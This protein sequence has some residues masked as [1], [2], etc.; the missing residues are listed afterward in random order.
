[1]NMEWAYIPIQ[2]Y[3]YCIYLVIIFLEMV[4]SRLRNW[5]K[6]LFFSGSFIG[7]IFTTIYTR[8]YKSRMVYWFTQTPYIHCLNETISNHPLFLYKHLY[9]VYIVYIIR[10]DRFGHYSHNTYIKPKIK[11]K[12]GFSIF[13]WQQMNKCVLLTDEWNFMKLCRKTSS[14]S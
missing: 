7:N 1:M 2:I 10:T 3:L 13:Y 11:I 6:V 4:S 8:N 5:I 9:K 12:M 14:S